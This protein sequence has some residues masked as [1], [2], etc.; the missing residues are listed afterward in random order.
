MDKVDFILPREFYLD[1]T[2]APHRDAECPRCKHNDIVKT[3]YAD[4]IEGQL[5]TFLGCRSCHF[6][7]L[8]GRKLTLKECFRRSG[9]I[10][11]DCLSSS[12]SY[13]S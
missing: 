2:M 8:L 12:L 4:E 5:R 3:T 1:V 9:L 6:R 7:W 11:Y 13:S 10:G